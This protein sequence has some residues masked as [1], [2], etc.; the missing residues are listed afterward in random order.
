M[1]RVT[2]PTP[3]THPIISNPTDPK[4]F[5]NCSDPVI[6]VVLLEEL[7]ELPLDVELVLLEELPEELL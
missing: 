5:S 2:T 1:M 4:G 6:L 3:K 7:P